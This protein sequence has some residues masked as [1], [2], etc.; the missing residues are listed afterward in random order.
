[1]AA[2]IVVGVGGDGE[3]DTVSQEEAIAGRQHC[4]NPHMYFYLRYFQVG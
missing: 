1:M 3:A 2:A 4:F